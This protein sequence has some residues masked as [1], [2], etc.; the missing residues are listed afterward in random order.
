MDVQLVKTFQFEASHVS[1]AGKGAPDEPHGHSYRVDLK[2]AGAIDDELGWL[3]DYGHIKELFDPVYKR[4]DHRHLND[5]DSMSDILLSGAKAW[6]E[7]ELETGIPY[8]H[9]VEVSIVG[10][11]AFEPVERGPGSIAFG[12]E[13]AHYLPRLPSSHKCSHMHGH[14]FTVEV[15][16]PGARDLDRAVKTI[17]DALDHRCLNAVDGLDNPTSEIVS[18]WIWDRLQGGVPELT[19][20]SV[21]ETCTSRC[22]Y[23]GRE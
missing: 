19:A 4:I 8:F 16:A 1:P 6:L 5:V 18:R 13:A 3:V 15:A 12:F 11:C 7:A 22:E 2:L 9:G 14:S 17:Y 23:H 10:P 20:V 21:A